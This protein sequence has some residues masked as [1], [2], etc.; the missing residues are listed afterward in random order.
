MRICV[1]GAGALG[2]ALGGLL[3]GNH[4]VILVGRKA[5]VKAIRNDG[6]ILLGDRRG[7][8]RVSAAESLADVEPTELVVLTTKAYDT[9]DAVALLRPWA[10][11]RTK[12]L[13]LQNGLGNLEL[14]RRWKGRRAFG[15]VTTMGAT[16]LGPGR[17]RIAG[18]GKT[19]VGTDADARGA[20]A[21]AEALT[22]SGIPTSTT[23]DIVGE[24][25]GKAIVN[26]CI[27]PVTAVLRVTNGR[28]LESAVIRRLLSEVCEECVAVA[29]REGVCLSVRELQKKAFKIARDTARNRSSMLQDVGNGKPT[30][31]HQING[32]FAALGDRHGVKTP[33][34]D[35]LAAMVR[36]LELRP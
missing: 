36:A 30:E 4:E 31:I 1:F 16:L 10:E 2:S 33:L 29:L 14:L 24:I 35:V 34:N 6:L 15:G 9:Q 28:L 18:L 3:A 20:R 5:H 8:V 17:V 23:S 12:I 11:E 22:S 32:A 13:T 25:W 26:A 7:R 19:V 27:N 21:I